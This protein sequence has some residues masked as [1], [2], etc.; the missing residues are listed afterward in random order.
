[1][2]RVQRR[3]PSYPSSPASHHPTSTAS[4]KAP[5]LPKKPWSTPNHILHQRVSSATTVS[6]QHIR[7]CRPFTRHAACLLSTEF[8][9]HNAWNDHVNH[10]SSS[11]RTTCPPPSSKLPP[12]T[13]LPR[14][15]C[16][17]LN[18]LRSGTA[19]V[20]ETLHHWGCKIQ[21]YACVGTPH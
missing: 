10:G 12:G 1:M 17:R 11:I 16:V 15:L 13:D 2:C 20:G 9:T 21:Q 6:R 7:S 8:D 5:I 4:H 18:H 14:K 19:R 3:L